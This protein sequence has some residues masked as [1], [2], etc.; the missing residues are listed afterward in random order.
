MASSIIFWIHGAMVALSY[1]TN[2]FRVFTTFTFE[3]IGFFLVSFV[4]VQKNKT[5][6]RLLASMVYKLVFTLC[7]DI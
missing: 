7:L 3:L 5:L 4:I 6:V 2:Y 1:R